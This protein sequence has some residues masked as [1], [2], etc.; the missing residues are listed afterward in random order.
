MTASGG[1]SIDDPLACVPEDAACDAAACA[2]NVTIHLA[3]TAAA[4]CRLHV[5]SATGATFDDDV[6]LTL[7]VDPCGAPDGV[8]PADANQWWITA[9]FSTDGGARDAA[10]D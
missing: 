2:C 8:V 10:T 5:T 6:P 9:D 7:S 3:Q 4:D 1:C